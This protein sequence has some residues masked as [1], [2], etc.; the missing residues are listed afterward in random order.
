MDVLAALC[1]RYLGEIVALDEFWVQ[2][3]TD[4]PTDSELT[5]TETPHAVVNMLCL[6]IIRTLQD[7]EPAETGLSPFDYEGADIVANAVLTR[8]SDRFEELDSTDWRVELW[9]PNFCQVVQLLRQSVPFYTL[10]TKPS[11]FHRP[12]CAERLPD[13][14]NRVISEAF[15]TRI[16]LVLKNVQELHIVEEYVVEGCQIRG[17]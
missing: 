14:Y 9:Y 15:R 3:N 16:A 10:A 7:L 1:M 5:A 11:N 4:K 6:T 13:S 17:Y 8:V 12:W 2:L